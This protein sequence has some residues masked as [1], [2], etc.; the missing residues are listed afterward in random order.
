MKLYAAGLAL[1][2]NTFVSVPTTYTDFYKGTLVYGD[3]PADGSSP[4][5]GLAAFIA[6][7]AR[8]R[9]WTLVDG[10]FADGGA[11]GPATRAAYESLRD[12]ILEQL[13]AAMPVDLVYLALHGAMVATGYDDC[14]GDLLA[15]VR[16]IVG[17]AL[18]IG[19]VMDSHCHLTPEMVKHATL[20]VAFKEWPHTDVVESAQ[21]AFDLLVRVAEGQIKPATSVWDCRMIQSYP[22]DKEPMRG[23]VDRLKA[24]E[25]QDGVPSE[26]PFQKNG[27]LSVSVVHGFSH[28]DVPAMGTKI[29]VVTDDRPEFG[30]RLAEK[31]GRELFSMRESVGL[32]LLTIEEALDRSSAV[33]GSPVVW[34]DTGDCV[35]G[36]APGDATYIL[37]ALLE[38][39]VESAAIHSLR[40]PVAVS[41]AMSAGVGAQ[42]DM[43]IGAKF[44]PMSGRPL[45]LPVTVTEV[46]PGFKLSVGNH[47]YDFGDT[48][49][50]RTGGIHIVL[51]TNKAWVLDP[52]CFSEL[53]IDPRNTHILVVKSIHNFYAWFAPIAAEVL[54]VASPGETVLD[55]TLL[56]YR[57]ANLHQWPLVEDPF[58]R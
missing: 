28:G 26:W 19:V 58:S 52:E 50:V 9:G 41:I 15:R 10:L 47:K 57:R 31:L 14:E 48:V 34:A 3:V 22:T 1:E 6:G 30:A 51:T 12:E 11:A 24:L 25:G 17:P 4:A 27:V 5:R 21:A 55:V 35:G 32:D 37:E 45:D 2:A 20:M 54:T 43:R 56:P 53:G 39:G 16:E 38:R 8:Q 44:A 18:P 40:D 13:R 49:V 23:F 7:E 46:R 29:L 42:L 36:G 33:D